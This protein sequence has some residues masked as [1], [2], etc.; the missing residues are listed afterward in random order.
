MGEKHRYHV[1]VSEKAKRMLGE[2]ILFLARVDKNAARKKK[3]EIMK[4]LRSLQTMPDRYPFI[5]D[6]WFP[7]DLYH[8]MFVPKW[9]L[10]IYQIRDNDVYVDYIL[11]CRRDYDWLR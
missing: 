1:I 3:N 5:E 8:K 10:I 2:H 7:H 4:A 11:D 9:Y 6:E